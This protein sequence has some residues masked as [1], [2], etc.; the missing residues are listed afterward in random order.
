MSR[1]TREKQ[2]QRQL[3]AAALIR[4]RRKTVIIATALVLGICLTAGALARWN[5]SASF[6]PAPFQ[7]T[8]TP[9]PVTLSKEYVYAGGGG[10]LL[11]VIDKGAEAAV[12]TDLAVWRLST[13]A[14]YVLANGTTTVS[15]NWGV[16]TDLPAPGDYDG[17]GK[18]DF[19]VYRP[20]TS[21]AFYILATSTNALQSATFGGASDVPVPGDYDGD[22]RSDIG[23]YRGSNSTFYIIRTSDNQLATL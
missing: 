1:L 8:P 23:L 13:G 14:W 4:R 9:T 12:P 17:D 6:M 19:S 15:S 16:S 21:G 5:S 7:P 10:R 3:E 20:G 18:V 22:G 11:S 2:I